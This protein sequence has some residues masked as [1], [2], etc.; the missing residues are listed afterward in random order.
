[1]KGHSKCPS[2][3]ARLARLQE[4]V[5]CHEAALLRYTARIVGNDDRARD[6]V[7][8]AFLR[9]W[10]S[11]SP[12]EDSRVAQWLFAVCRNR[13]ID[14]VRKERRMDPLTDKAMASAEA[15]GVSPSEAVERRETRGRL[16]RMIDDLPP[17]QQEVIRLKFQ[18]GFSYRQIAGITGKSV[19][20]VGVLL[21]AAIQALRR[22]LKVRPA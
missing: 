18:N 19:S 13:A 22:K 14:V 11:D 2:R 16:L 1:M 3:A 17:S 4:V 21:H 8:D 20:N 10:K 7:Q 5:D 15:G 6:I 9:L 12:P